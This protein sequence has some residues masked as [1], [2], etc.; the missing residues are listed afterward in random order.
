MKRL[1]L[2]FIITACL[3]LASAL[4]NSQTVYYEASEFPLIGKIT[5]ETETR[6]ERLP[7]YLKDNVSRPAIWN[8]GKNTSGLAIRFN[9]NSTSISAKWEVLK[10]VSMNHFSDTGIKGLDLYA[11]ENNKWQ[12]VRSARPTGKESEQVIISSMSPKDREF[13][14]FLPLYDGLTSLSIGV[15]SLSS[16]GLP[17]MNL[18]ITKKPIVVYGTSITQGGCATRPGMSY[19]NILT[20][21]MNREFINLGFSGNGKLD[22]EIAGA[23]TKRKDAE[24]FI[25]DFIPNVTEQQIKNKT[26][27]FVDIIRK[28]NPNTPILLIES[29]IFP[30][31]VFSTETAELLSAKNNALRA[32]YE[33]MKEAGDNHLYYLNSENLLSKDG[34]GT[35]D[36]VH[37]T[38]LGFQHFAYTLLKEIRTILP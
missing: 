2:T 28:E 29:I 16:I 30:H 17:R 25:L 33:K 12:F 14:L 18:P 20:R 34:E 8:L 3:L 27:Y 36:G 31:S 10:D 35:V 38:D 1:H 5:T 23:M 7:A 6:Y 15:D 11:W 22:Y 26:K 13:M 24:M 4:L 19:T 37:L 32:E 21:W 9:S